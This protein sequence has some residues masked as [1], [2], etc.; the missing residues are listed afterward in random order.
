MHLNIICKTSIFHIRYRQPP[1]P[2]PTASILRWPANNDDYFVP[3]ISANLHS[4][5]DVV[6]SEGCFVNP[7]TTRFRSKTTTYPYFILHVE[8]D[9]QMPTEMASKFLRDPAFDLVFINSEVAIFQSWE[10]QSRRV[11]AD[12]WWDRLTKPKKLE[13]LFFAVFSCLV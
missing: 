6:S 13:V 4:F 5:G 12:A 10:P 1:T 3:L 11:N 7:L 2:S 8:G 9:Q